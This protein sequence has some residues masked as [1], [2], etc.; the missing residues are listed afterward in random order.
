MQIREYQEWLEAWD[1]ARAWEQVTMSHTLLHALEELG[2]VSKLVQ[3]IAVAPISVAARHAAPVIAS[4][5]RSS[6][7]TSSVRRVARSRR[8]QLS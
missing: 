2:E 7:S 1:R 5:T 6:A 8:A 4:V 3:M